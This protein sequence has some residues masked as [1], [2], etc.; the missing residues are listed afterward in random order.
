MKKI[1]L[2]MLFAISLQAADFYYEYGKKVMIVKTYE[3]RDA[4]G[5]KYYKNS[6]GKK[7]GVKDEIIVQCKEGIS[8]RENLG[9]YPVGEVSRLSDRMLLVKVPKDENIF[10]LSQKL[11]E[12]DSIAFAHPNFIKERSRR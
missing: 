8:C 11:Y 6:L 7:I 2:I 9:K 5:V 1:A 4:K 10:E 3:G 12:D